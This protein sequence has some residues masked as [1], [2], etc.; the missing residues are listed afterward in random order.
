M[1][2]LCVYSAEPK[3]PATDQH[4]DA[5][6]YEI[7]GKWVDAI[8][9]EPTQAEL[10]AVLTPDPAVLDQA[11]LNAALAAPGSVVRALALVLLQEINTIRTRLPTPLAAY[12]QAQLVA[13][14]KAKMR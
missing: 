9:G 12:T 6:R 10:D 8:G 7:A 13:A 5:A 11:T 1:T 4:P 14:L 3:F 2:I